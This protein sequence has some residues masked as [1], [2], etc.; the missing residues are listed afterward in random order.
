MWPAWSR[1]RDSAARPMRGLRLRHVLGELG[2]PQ[3]GLA[4]GGR[5]PIA[6]RGQRAA[7]GDLRAVG[8]RRALELAE[9][10][11]AKQEDLEPVLDL[12]ERIG[13]AFGRRD[14][15]RPGTALD[16]APGVV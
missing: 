3:V 9:R 15:G 14:V 2:E 7:G 8:Q 10:K 5:A 12:A 16:V 4:V 11:E 13:A 6:A 1:S